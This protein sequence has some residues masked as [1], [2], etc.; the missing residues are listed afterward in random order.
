[1]HSIL[2]I[3]G[4]IALLLL[5]VAAGRLIGGGDRRPMSR[6]ALYFLPV[7]FVCA[8]VN[9]YVGVTQAGFSVAQELPFFALVFGVPSAAAFVAY[10]LWTRR[11]NE[12]RPSSA[13]RP[14]ED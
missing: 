4:G 6:A 13:E 11:T 10:R 8:A 2:V 9:M 3:T 1:M 5:F 14:G 12:Q 7:W